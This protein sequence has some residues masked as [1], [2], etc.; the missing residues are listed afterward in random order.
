L[1][2]NEFGIKGTS[3]LLA[4]TDRDGYRDNVDRVPL[5]DAFVEISIEFVYVLGS[6]PHNPNSMPN[7]F[8]KVGIQGNTTYTTRYWD[9]SARWYTF[10]DLNRYDGHRLSVNVPDDAA[11]LDF[12]VGM[13]SYD[14]RG[15]NEHLPVGVARDTSFG[16][17]SDVN[18]TTIRYNLQPA[19]QSTVY[20]P[21]GGCPSSPRYANP[22]NL[23]LATIVPNRIAASLNSLVAVGQLVYDGLVALGTFLADLAEAIADWGMRFFGVVSKAVAGA[24]G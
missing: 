19:G 8:V 18:K 15:Y 17:C 3:P 23:T 12:M 9:R 4:D 24:I 14:D 16:G 20:H 5:G 1:T 10:D 22:L 6:D 11:Y 2:D 13:W 21:S 7:P